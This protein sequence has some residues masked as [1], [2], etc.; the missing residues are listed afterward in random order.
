MVCGVILYFVVRPSWWGKVAML[1]RGYP[2][3]GVTLCRLGVG[4]F[5]TCE[6]LWPAVGWFNVRGI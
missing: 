6:N 2:D 5:P 3:P 1:V 4:A